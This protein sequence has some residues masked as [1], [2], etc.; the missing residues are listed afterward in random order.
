MN[1]K[2]LIF[3]YIYIIATILIIGWLLSYGIESGSVRELF[4]KMDYWWLAGGFACIIMH[5]FMDS[6]IVHQ[7]IPFIARVKVGF[8]RCIKYGIVGL[9]YAALTPFATGGQ[10]A[11]IVYMKRDGIPVGKSTAI[12]SVKLFVHLLSM[13]FSF[14]LYMFLRGTSFYRDYKAI[15]FIT[16]MGFLVNL[17][18]VVF[19]FIVMTNTDKAIRLIKWIIKILHKIKLV[20]HE[21]KAYGRIEKVI[22]DF[23][24][25]SGYI[26]THKFKTFITFVLSYIKLTFMFAVPFMVFKAFNLTGYGPLDLISL[27]TFV[28]LTVS[29]MPTPGT[30]FAAEGGFRLVYFPV[31]GAYTNMAIAAWRIITYYSIL[32]IGALLVIIDQGIRI[33][34][35]PKIIK[36]PDNS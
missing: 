9:Y 3:S 20:K 31:F 33:K 6:V 8:F 34:K 2:K 22:H 17:F 25:A 13:C 32:I 11:Q 24:E 7:I 29:F 28:F 36:E 16:I 27:N 21:E 1:N 18:G 35:N 4:S 19:I 30:S 5:W 12:V 26:K 15:F 14:M 23:A 10:P